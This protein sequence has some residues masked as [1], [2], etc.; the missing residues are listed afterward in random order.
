ME[1]WY[2][3]YYKRG[4]LLRAK[5]HLE[6]QAVNCLSPM[7]K[8]EK[9]VRRKRAEVSEPLFPNYLF[10][11]FDSERIHTTTIGS[12]RGVSHFIRFSALPAVIPLSVITELAQHPVQVIHDPQTSY[13][14]DTMLITEEVFTGLQVIYSESN[15]EARSMLLLNLLNKQV[16]Q[17]IDSRQFKKM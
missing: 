1:A 6:H 14:G 15:G 11:E 2:L 7:I 3:L 12:T 17:S 13:P 16:P 8:I 5:E 10:I 9:I 4:Q